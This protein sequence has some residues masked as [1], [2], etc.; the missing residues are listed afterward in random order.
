MKMK[1]N[2]LNDI[3]PIIGDDS[4]YYSDY[5]RNI[6]NEHN[7]NC[8]VSMGMMQDYQDYLNLY[9]QNYEIKQI[10]VTDFVNHIKLDWISKRDL[11]N[12]YLEQITNKEINLTS[13]KVT[14]KGDNNSN[15]TSLQ[16]KTN[17]DEFIDMAIQNDNDTPT[18]KNKGLNDQSSESE[19]HSTYSS[20]KFKYKNVQEINRNLINYKSEY[21]LLVDIFENNFIIITF[22]FR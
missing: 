11:F 18:T 5:L 12:K 3:K 10:T 19:N 15:G 2:K 8:L 4:P 7:F 14:I 22:N 1:I 20:D 21:D 16:N 13:D 6:D 17:Q 9:F